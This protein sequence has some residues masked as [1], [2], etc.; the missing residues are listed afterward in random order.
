MDCTV[1]CFIFSPCA[2]CLALVLTMHTTTGPGEGQEHL[3][4]YPDQDQENYA[5]TQYVNADAGAKGLAETVKEIS[6]KSIKVTH[7]PM[8]S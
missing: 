3:F 7:T 8:S 2:S 6:A 5:V 1:V 4:F